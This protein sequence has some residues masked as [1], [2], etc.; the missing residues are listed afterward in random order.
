MHIM[1][2]IDQTEGLN[3]GGRMKSLGLRASIPGSQRLDVNSSEL[4]GKIREKCMQN[5][6]GHRINGD[7]QTADAATTPSPSPP[8]FV[9]SDSLPSAHPLLM[10]IILSVL[11]PSPGM[12]AFSLLTFT[13][14]WMHTCTGCHCLKGASPCF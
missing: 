5:I 11:P 3:K 6:L 1:G 7:R 2:L 13:H 12:S 8:L 10:L 14:C 9:L 4:Q